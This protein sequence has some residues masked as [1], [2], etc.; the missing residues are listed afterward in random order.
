[1]MIEHTLNIYQKPKLGSKF[2]RR[3][4]L[5][6]YR[7]R[8][9]AQ[10]WFDTATADIAMRDFQEAQ[11]FCLNFI[12]NRVAV[13]V[14]DPVTPAWEGFI[15]RITANNGSVGFT[16]SLDEMGNRIT[17]KYTDGT[18]ATTPVPAVTSAVDNLTSQ[19]LYGI[20]QSEMEFGYSKFAA[21]GAIGA[22]RDSL[23]VNRAFPQSSVKEGNGF[24]MHLEMLGFY[25]TLGW[26]TYTSIATGAAPNISTFITGTILP[27][28][29]NGSTF[30]DKTDTSEIATSAITFSAQQRN[31]ATLWDLLQKL[32]E[33]GDGADGF[34][35]GIT[36]TNWNTGKRHLY[37]RKINKAIRYHVNMS[38]RLR[39]RTQNRQVVAPWRVS[40]DNGARIDDWQVFYNL[41]GDDPRFTYIYGVDYDGNTQSVIYNGQDDRRIQGIFDLGRAF[42]RFGRGFGAR[43]RVSDG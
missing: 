5:I 32:A 19:A 12:G 33:I 8:I 31:G 42:Q 18:T 15:N 41:P 14:D 17:V 4:H 9:S 22:L 21:A 28:I 34:I 6:N 20:K 36:P 24:L 2:I 10:G 7:H 3:L 23:L 29:D 11:E 38:E 27:N 43:M 35:V 37:Y 25:H 40:P 13:F 26:E 1:M 39:V 16:I 30:F